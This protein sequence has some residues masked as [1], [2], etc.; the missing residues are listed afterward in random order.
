MCVCVY[1]GADKLLYVGG[2][3]CYN[4]FAIPVM[5][6]CCPTGLMARN[7]VTK[8]RLLNGGW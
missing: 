7:K 8:R 1:E 3:G 6:S 2:D 4:L 5:S